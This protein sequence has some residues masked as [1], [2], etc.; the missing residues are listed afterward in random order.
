M[1]STEV[2]GLIDE[3]PFRVYRQIKPG[4]P[5]RKLMFAIL[6]DAIQ[7]YQKFADSKSFRGKA[8]C[9]KE[10]AWFWSE[11]F[12]RVFSFANIC[13]VLGLNP[14]FFR[15]RLRQLT[16]IHKRRVSRGK[17][18]QLRPIANRPRKLTFSR[19]SRGSCFT[20]GRQRRDA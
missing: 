9:R 17:V 14:A 2:N 12:D 3:K 10:E 18:F 15:W 8:L 4:D 5:E 20:L 6:V 11:D 1:I 13:E 19:P 7:T 16:I